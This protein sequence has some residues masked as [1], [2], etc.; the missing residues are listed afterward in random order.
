MNTKAI[1]GAIKASLKTALQD[2]DAIGLALE[3]LQE[4]ADP[5]DKM[6]SLRQSLAHLNK[7]VHE[8]NAYHNALS[9]Q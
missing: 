6:E 9:T 5:K 8:F 4:G 1:R 2:V 7:A 3:D